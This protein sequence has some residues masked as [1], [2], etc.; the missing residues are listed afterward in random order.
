MRILIDT[1]VILDVLLRREPFYQAGRSVLEMA[2]YSEIEEIISASA[3][4]DIYYVVNRTMKNP[5][6]VRE[7]MSRLLLFVRVATVSEREIRYA[8]ELSWDDFEDAV[9]YSAAFF[10]RTD[11]VVT[12]DAAGFSLAQLPIYSP[13]EFLMMFNLK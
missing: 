3:V 10:A 11:A 13:D 9:Q 5:A 7:L 1:N 6:V 4:T 12:R 2:K 8:M